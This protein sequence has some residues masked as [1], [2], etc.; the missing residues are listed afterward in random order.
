MIARRSPIERR[1]PLARSTR[2]IRRRKTLAAVRAERKAK[3]PGVEPETWQAIIDWY[4]GRCAYCLQWPHCGRLEQDHVR[5]LSRGGQHCPENVVPADPACNRDK[6][7][8]WLKPLI[9]HPYK[10]QVSR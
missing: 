1:T 6:G 3:G 10:A 7:S 8:R 2:P 5:P 9:M 4:G